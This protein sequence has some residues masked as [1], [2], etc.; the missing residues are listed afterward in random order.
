[1]SEKEGVWS[2]EVKLGQTLVS[3]LM[4]DLISPVHQD[5]VKRILTA[6]VRTVPQKSSGTLY[7]DYTT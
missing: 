7:G 5:L 3:T 4:E 2:K 1:M 6:E